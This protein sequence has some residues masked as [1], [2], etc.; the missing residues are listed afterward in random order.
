LRGACGAGERGEMRHWFLVVL[1]TATALVFAGSAYAVQPSQTFV[2]S[3]DETIELSNDEGTCAFAIHL[4]GIQIFR[5]FYDRKGSAVVASAQGRTELT[6]TNLLTGQTISG[7]NSLNVKSTPLDVSTVDVGDVVTLHDEGAG[8]NAVLFPPDQ[9]PIVLAGHFTSEVV[10]RVLVNDPETGEFEAELISATDEATPL[11][12]HL[13]D[14]TA[15][16][17]CGNESN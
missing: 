12:G 13:L 3:F 4:D 16:L 5:L 1:A 10:F 15:E 9:P 8:L 7:F 6:L 14:T 17:F 2:R 11:L